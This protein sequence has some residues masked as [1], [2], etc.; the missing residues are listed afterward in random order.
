MNINKNKRFSLT[1]SEENP[2]L[3]NTELD[4]LLTNYANRL[5]LIYNPVLNQYNN[6]YFT[7]YKVEQA[8]LTTITCVVKSIIN[9]AETNVHNLK[10]NLDLEMRVK[11]SKPVNAFLEQSLEY[12]IYSEDKNGEIYDYT[13][14]DL[15]LDPLCPV[16]N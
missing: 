11:Q 14:L 13:L 2:Q 8:K 7:L 10:L 3:F 15:M 5:N 12:Y 6:D 16:S 1:V 4:L 9:G